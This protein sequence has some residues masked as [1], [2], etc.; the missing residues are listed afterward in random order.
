MLVESLR[1]RISINKPGFHK[2]NQQGLQQIFFVNHDGH[3]WAISAPHLLKVCIVNFNGPVCGI[4]T[5]QVFET[6][7]EQAEGI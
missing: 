5:F 7:L 4:I 1:W 2:V 3:C 6:Q